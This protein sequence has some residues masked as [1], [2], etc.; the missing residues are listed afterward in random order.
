M[1]KGTQEEVSPAF[2]P[3]QKISVVRQLLNS[4]YNVTDWREVIRLITSKVTI[5]LRPFDTKYITAG[6]AEEYF[7][8]LTDVTSGAIQASSDTLSQAY[9]QLFA[10]IYALKRADA[11]KIMGEQNIFGASKID[12]TLSDFRTKLSSVESRLANIEK[13]LLPSNDNWEPQSKFD[14]LTNKF[15]EFKD[16]VCNLHRG[17]ENLE[18]TVKSLITDITNVLVRIE[19]FLVTYTPTLDR[20]KQEYENMDR[21]IKP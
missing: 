15:E 16:E 6:K 7:K 12:V 19:K 18:S 14:E 8:F 13:I 10:F 2:S 1:D 5:P 20:A 4:T 11:I 17:V 9:D 3:T 21:R